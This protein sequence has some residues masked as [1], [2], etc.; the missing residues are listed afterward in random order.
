MQPPAS[1]LRLLYL[2]CIYSL[3]LCSC[4]NARAQVSVTD[5]I[6]LPSEKLSVADGLSQGLILSIVQDKQG[7]MWFGT[8]D[9]LNKYDGYHFTVYRHEQGNPYSLAGNYIKHIA[10][11]DNGNL[12]VGTYYNGLYLFDRA[13]EKFYPV[14]LSKDSAGNQGIYEMWY[15]KGRLIIQ[16]NQLASYDVGQ[17]HPTNYNNI[18]LSDKA[19]IFN[20]SKYI[21]PQRW[22]D[23]S[24]G[25]TGQIMPDGSIWFSYPDSVFVFAIK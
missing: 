3:A 4:F 22:T 25:L 9:G 20:R 19:I 13:A 2:L 17:I 15:A 6:T 21:A 10:E 8:M 11:D 5:T 1:L 16:T 12:W 7:I 14:K 23:Y 24:K 18:D